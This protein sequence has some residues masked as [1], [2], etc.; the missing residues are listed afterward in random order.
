MFSSTITSRFPAGTATTSGVKR[1]SWAR[2]RTFVVSPEGTTSAAAAGV[3]LPSAAGSMATPAAVA[4]TRADSPTAARPASWPLGRAYGRPGARGPGCRSAAGVLFARRE[5]RIALNSS[6][7]NAANAT[8]TSIETSTRT[9]LGTGSTLSRS[10]PF[11]M[12]IRSAL[13]RSR[14]VFAARTGVGPPPRATG[15]R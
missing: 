15:T 14:A 5:A 8:S 11:T 1:M 13:P 4:S 7:M 10:P 6:G 12:V 9:R 3:P 2:T